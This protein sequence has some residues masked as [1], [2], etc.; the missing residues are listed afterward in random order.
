MKKAEQP[1]E[2][3]KEKE[4]DSFT[5]T[6][7]S[8]GKSWRLPARTGSTGNRLV[9]I[10]ALYGDTGILTYDPGFTS[11]AACKSD[12]TYINGDKGVLLHRGY[13][14]D[15]L[16]KKSDFMETCYLLLYGELP[17]PEQKK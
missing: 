2:K 17:T 5:L 14:I 1:K 4:M 9:D 15:E 6:D 11:T 12:I 8:T 7:N 3:E 13:S 16:V 10:K